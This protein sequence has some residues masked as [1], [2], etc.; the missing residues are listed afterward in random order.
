MSEAPRWR[1]G[2]FLRYWLSRIP[3]RPPPCALAW[4]D[5]HAV[6]RTRPNAYPRDRSGAVL[7][8]AITQG[9]FRMLRRLAEQSALA[10]EFQRELEQLVASL[11]S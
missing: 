5:G 8:L 10:H 7:T 2:D 1:E 3:A 9:E 6:R 11:S 4:G